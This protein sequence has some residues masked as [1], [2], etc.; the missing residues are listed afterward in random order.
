MWYYEFKDTT[1]GPVTG[2]VIQQLLHAGV[3]GGRTLVC[4]EGQS[5][6]LPL[7][8]IPLSKWL[9]NT[10][11]PQC[12]P[13]PNPQ[14]EGVQFAAVPSAGKV[15]E[16]RT[17]QV[18]P[19]PISRDQVGPEEPPL[20]TPHPS[21]LN[22]QQFLIRKQ[23]GG[24]RVRHVCDILTSDS[25]TKIGEVREEGSR[26]VM[27]LRHAPL[28][29]YLMFVRLVIGL[30]P[31]WIHIYEVLDVEE[32]R[33]LL[34]SFRVW[35]PSR[36]LMVFNAKGIQ[37]G[38]FKRKRSLF[39]K[40]EYAYRFKTPEDREA[41]ALSGTMESSQFTLLRG[42]TELGSISFKHRD[43]FASP[44]VDCMIEVRDTPS[45]ATNRMLLA[46]WL[47]VVHDWGDPW[48]WMTG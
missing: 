34:F 32:P 33:K 36:R 42:E 2:E 19:V 6:W 4:R 26:F 38:Y 22:L 7:D 27:F 5:D 11:H 35:R 48:R 47:A 44:G 18:S 41:A 17:A 9:Q 14:P 24:L 30:I 16:G 21:L 25:E 1:I 8:G 28:W 13:S 15:G 39:S 10:R 31:K 43:L 20:A 12:A 29:S 23:T 45:L 46:S 37:V 40:G 3:I